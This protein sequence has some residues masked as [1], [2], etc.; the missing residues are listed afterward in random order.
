MWGRKRAG[1]CRRRIRGLPGLTF[2]DIGEVGTEAGDGFQDGLPRSKYQQR[3]G[4]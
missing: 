4:G 1:K 3:T 2:V